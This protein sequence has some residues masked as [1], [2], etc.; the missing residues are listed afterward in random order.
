MIQPGIRNSTSIYISHPII[1]VPMA[2]QVEKSRACLT[3]MTPA[4]KVQTD[5]TKTIMKPMNGMNE[6][7]LILSVV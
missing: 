1:Q 3:A 4:I 7:N 5:A 6:K 2:R